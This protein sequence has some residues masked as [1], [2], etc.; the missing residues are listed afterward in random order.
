MAGFVGNADVPVRD[1]IPAAAGDP[2]EIVVP[3]GAVR[4]VFTQVGEDIH[5]T[6]ALKTNAGA[7]NITLGNSAVSGTILS[8]SLGEVEVAGWFN[9]NSSFWFRAV[10]G[11]G[12][13]AISFYL[14]FE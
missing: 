8:G 7:A 10:A 11:G 3:Q 13:A 4:I 12:G 9:T 6:K 2:D 5:F 14:I 1:T